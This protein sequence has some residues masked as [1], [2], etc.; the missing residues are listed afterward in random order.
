VASNFRC[1]IVTPSES[2]FDDE[3]TYVSFPAW[4]GQH[5]VIAGS[6]PVL[7]RLGVGSLRIDAPEGG[8]RWYLI[9]GG[10]AQVAEGQ[11]SIVT[12][13]AQPAEQLVGRDFSEELEQ[14][15]SMVHDTSVDRETAEHE[16]NRALA[17]KS[18][19][20]AM[21]QRGRAI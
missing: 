21:E 3:A 1:S 14:A 7:T 17:K 16:M 13:S 15:S 4:D 10:F 8:S 12:E 20:A 18:L 11:L 6:S 5:G 9:D 19:V 2:V